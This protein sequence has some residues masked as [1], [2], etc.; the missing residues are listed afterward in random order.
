M[1]DNIKSRTISG[2]FF[3]F[4]ERC[5]AQTI[6]FI[7]TIVLARILIPEEYGIVAIVLTLILICDVFVTYGFGNS[8]VVNKGSDYIDFS[9]CF[10]FS[11]IFSLLVYTIIYVTAPF[12][13]NF[14]EYEVLISLIRF[15]G[16]RI[17]IAAINSVQE[18]YVS[19]NMMFK[20]SFFASLIGTSISGITSVIM[21]YQGFGVWALAFQNICN[22]SLYAIVL[23]I[24]VGWRPSLI[25]SFNRLI[26]IY[27]YGWKILV[28]GLLDRIYSQSRN[29]VIAKKY[30]SSELA[31]YNKGDQFP[32]LA[33]NIIEP[34]LNSVIFPA[35]S[36]CNDDMSLMKSAIRRIVKSTTFI[37]TPI[38]VGLAC[39][40]EPLVLFLLT[41]KW[42]PCVIF[43][44]I[45]C[46]AYILRPIQ[47]INGCIIRAS[48]KSGLLLKLDVFKKSL[49]II[50]LFLSLKYGPIGIAFSFVITNIIST[51][52][53][54]FPNRQLI[55]YGYIEQIK[56]IVPGFLLSA[57]MGASIFS[58][59]Y[60]QIGILFK[61]LIQ[62]IV[63]AL[64]Y[65]AL[66]EFFKVESYNYFKNM[67]KLKIGR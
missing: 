54:I 24:I 65:I 64:I 11:I 32:G 53:N 41:H 10:Y 55:R 12:I 14:F 62:I 48:G 37:V 26:K 42:L 8:L 17:P 39:I 50:L 16:I 13:A 51:M 43:L 46:L 60:L 30:S 4:A 61:L 21:A 15:M 59:G 7:V 6:S 44:Q 40:A 57:L 20:K 49:G 52:I 56:D 34:T 19:K 25:F 63:G 31:F 66:S 27:D 58:L 38:I 9:T 33:I 29:I 5:G 18:A 1:I 2:L 22:I 47:V 23:W 67:I 45:S 35:L 3:K 36:Q 28:V